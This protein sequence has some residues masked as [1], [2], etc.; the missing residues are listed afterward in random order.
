M[1]D[2]VASAD[3]ARVR[4]RVTREETEMK[5]FILREGRGRKGKGDEV[6][7]R[8]KGETEEMRVLF[9]SP[10]RHRQEVRRTFHG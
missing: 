3:V 8:G 5:D 6:V 7:G 4:A 2:L 9:S 10:G 1:H